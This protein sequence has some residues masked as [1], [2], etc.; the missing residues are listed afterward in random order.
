M[1]TAI[2]EDLYKLI[3]ATFSEYGDDSEIIDTPFIDLNGLIVTEKYNSDLYQ[4]I[5]RV[6]LNYEILKTAEVPEN[7]EIPVKGSQGYI[8]KIDDLAVI[9][10][11]EITTIKPKELIRFK[12]IEDTTCVVYYDKFEELKV[13]IIGRGIL[14]NDKYR[15]WYP[16]LF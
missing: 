16:S 4:E 12:T 15:I 7:E 3:K 14:K 9:M 1:T 10:S 8:L 11:E 13:K 5:L 6:E 2:H